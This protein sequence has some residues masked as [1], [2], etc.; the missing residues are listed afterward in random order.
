[1]CFCST[2]SV[3][4][5][6]KGFDLSLLNSFFWQFLFLLKKYTHDAITGTGGLVWNEVLEQLQSHKVSN[7]VQGVAEAL[8]NVKIDALVVRVWAW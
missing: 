8:A 5:S 7:G 4:L 1:M 3:A 6:L 2:W